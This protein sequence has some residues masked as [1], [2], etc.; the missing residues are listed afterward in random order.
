MTIYE[1]NVSNFNLRYCYSLRSG[2]GQCEYTCNRF[3]Q[4]E[5]EVIT[6]IARYCKCTGFVACISKKFNA[7]INIFDYI[8]AELCLRKM[9]FRNCFMLK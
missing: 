7:V 3:S 4:K 2:V 5:R 1:E 9:K 6:I 8:Y